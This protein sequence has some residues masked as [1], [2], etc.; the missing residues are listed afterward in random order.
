[1]QLFTDST[2]TSTL[3]IQIIYMKGT[4]R[5][6][7]HREK[8]ISSDINA[9]QEE[10]HRN[11]YPAS[12]TSALRNLDGTT[13]NNTRKHTP[14]CLRYIKGRAEKIQKICSPYDMTIFRSGLTLWKYFFWIIVIFTI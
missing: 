1:M 10:M 7:Q 12:I 8:S 6:L 14:V 9:Y 5:C 13:E 4:I 3:S 11:N 2:S